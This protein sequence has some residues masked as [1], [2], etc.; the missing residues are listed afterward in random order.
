MFRTRDR[1][2]SLFESSLLLPAEK[3]ARLDR[4]WARPFRD[5]ALPRIDE[6]A[7]AD[8]YCADNGRP[9]KPVATVVGMLILKEMFD[10]TDEEALA[11]LEFDLRWHVALGL[12]SGEAH[13]C[14]K[15]LHNFR[16]KL[17]ASD[18][19]ALLF[20]QMTGRI[21]EALGLSTDRQRLDS[22]H[23][24][25]N[26]AR[27]TRLGLFCE[28]IRLFLRDLSQSHPKL[29]AQVPISLG[30]R[31]LKEDGQPTGYADARRE[32]GRRRLPVAGRDLWRL[33]DR[34]DHH[35]HI[36]KWDSFGLLKRLLQEQCE[37]TTKPGKVDSSEAD[38]D[39]APVP[40]KVKEAKQVGS[41]SLQSPHDAD[42]T[43]GHKGKGYEVQVAETY[44]NKIEH[45][46]QGKQTD[47][48]QDQAD[49]ARSAD[50]VKPEM[51]TYVALTNSCGSDADAALPA[52]A[53][54][55]QRNL[56]PE[57]LVADTTYSSTSN[58]L[59]A[60]AK[61]V[62][63]I[64]PVAG[65]VQ[66]PVDEEVTIGDFQIN[67]EDASQ[68]RCPMEHR[69][70]E[71]LYDATTGKLTL[72]FESTICR[73]CRFKKL[74]PVQITPGRGRTRRHVLKTDLKSAMIQKRLRQQATMAFKD[75]YDNRAGIEA[76][77][78]EL[79]RA[80]GLGFL[81]V[82][83]R[84]PAQLAVCL[85]ALACNVKRFVR[86]LAAKAAATVRAQCSCQLVPAGN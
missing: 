70:S 15:T 1:Q 19:S 75:V 12:E 61:Q 48:P 26:M 81:R 9:N 32:E 11:S 23:I 60:K 8:L 51:I 86:Y 41:D 13:C 55:A 40:V 18:R 5:A 79:K 49:D 72:Y 74:C 58:V 10:L 22:T 16:A 53:N 44:G 85:K 27:L 46:D 78:S 7:F 62:T 43:Y 28:T 77:N 37:T 71:Q 33:V 42:A 39:L 64:G 54:L 50:V 57:E 21:I 63:L 17:I 59:A 34:F 65:N 36:S 25:S 52:M 47:S 68:T 69:P 4:T 56:C 31:Y 29:F 84:G 38:A 82:R 83:G 73:G 3:Q 24:T 6:R 76:T 30:R 14:Q 80:H 66:R 20:E 35:A 67:E 2:N 45:E